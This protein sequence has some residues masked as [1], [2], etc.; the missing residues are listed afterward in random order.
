MKMLIASMLA[1]FACVAIGLALW[2]WWGRPEFRPPGQ[3]ITDRLVGKRPMTP[4]EN[5]RAAE[6]MAR[7]AAARR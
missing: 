1:L 6:D 5:A 3:A 7:A 4:E 2:W